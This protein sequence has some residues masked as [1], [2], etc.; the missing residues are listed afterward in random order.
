MNKAEYVFEKIAKKDSMSGAIELED[1]LIKNPQMTQKQFLKRYSKE[2][3]H[4]PGAKEETLHPDRSMGAIGAGIG[5]ASSVAAQKLFGTIGPVDKTFKD[6]ARTGKR[7]VGRAALIGAAVGVLARHSAAISA[8][9]EVIDP[10][11]SKR[12]G[13]KFYADT[14][15]F[16]LGQ[17]T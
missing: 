17:K 6:I 14:K 10:A 8:N 12:K 2:V 1:D 3:V 9:R 13:I 7:R 11:Y 5:A 4:A 15:K 16:A